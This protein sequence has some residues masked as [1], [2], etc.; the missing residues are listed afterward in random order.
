[1]QTASNQFIPL[2]K[3]TRPNLTT[4]E[5]AFFLNRQPQT[6]RAWACLEH[7]PIRPVRIS[8]RLAWPLAGIR[9]LLAGGEK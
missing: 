3:I 7:G 1:M 8:G 4:E 5:A 9:A 6:L 2:E